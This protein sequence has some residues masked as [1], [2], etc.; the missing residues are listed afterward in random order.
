[1]VC[2][3]G[4]ELS[5]ELRGLSCLSDSEVERRTRMRGLEVKGGVWTEEQSR[6]LSM[7][8]DGS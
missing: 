2:G 3:E 5:F 8:L 1:M 4:R 7:A 6:W